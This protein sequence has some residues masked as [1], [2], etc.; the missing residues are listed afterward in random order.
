MTQIFVLVDIEGIAGV[1]SHHE[2]D[3]DNPEYAMARRLMTAE[4]SA[5]V[6]GIL[7]ADPDARVTVAD[8]HGP[9]RNLLPEELD[10]RARLI[11]GK[12]A[13]MGMVDGLTEDFDAAIFVGVH[14]KGGARRSALSHSFTDTILDV[15][16]NGTSFGELGINAAV[17][18]AMGVPV[19]MVAG[20]QV[21]REEARDLL[22]PDVITLVVKESRGTGRAGSPHPEKVRAALRAAAKD[23]LG[24]RSGI[25]PL[26]IDPPVTVEVEVSDSTIL[27]MAELIDGAERTSGR[28]I[29]ASKPD[30]MAAYR[31][32][33]L[34]VLLCAV[35]Y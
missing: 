13:T 18:G 23:A 30:M 22:G 34:I 1:V 7:D 11:R 19:I 33:R 9:F 15:R 25:T 3:P 31:F 8:A 6:A 26:R 14:G 21:V 16:I 24:L 28:T 4:A 20:D 10:S 27:D 17:A 32:L 5:V 29:R 2:G 35:S 12:P